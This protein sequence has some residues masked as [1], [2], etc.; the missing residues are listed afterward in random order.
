M[1]TK[2]NNPPYVMRLL[3]KAPL[4]NPESNPI[5]PFLL[6]EMAFWSG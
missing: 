4:A 2:K 3:C 1:E 5:R 6:N